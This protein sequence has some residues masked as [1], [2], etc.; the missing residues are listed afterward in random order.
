[1]AKPKVLV[2][3]VCDRF[4]IHQQTAGAR[5]T[6]DWYARFLRPFTARFG[7]LTVDD[8]TPSRV[9]QWITDTYGNLSASAQHAA[10]RAVV[11]AFNFAV[12]ER[13]IPTSPLIGFRKPA[14]SRRESTVTPVQY[15]ACLKAAV[16]S[17]RVDGIWEQVRL[18]IRDVIK[19]LWHTG[20]RPQELRIIEA[21]HVAGRKIVLPRELSKGK[22]R[23]RVIY[24]NDT[25]AAIVER[26][27]AEHPTGKLFRNSN[28][29]AWTK[30]ALAHAFRRLGRQA[31]IEG[32][33]CYS[34][35]HAWIT[36]QLE[37]G[38]DVAT[39]AALAGNSPRMVLDVYSHVAENEA[40]LL[41]VLG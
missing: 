39:V 41:T 38:T 30:T 40:R 6:Y 16:E 8:I 35:R 26:L 24:L 9:H 21:C 19:M 27:S 3:I 25:A 7:S 29:G 5:S 28:G 13:I 15:A 1:M 20:C 12:Q 2:T 22:R 34:F 31:G 18:P 23:Q 10:A 36:R 4:L 17:R 33:C 32:L 37:K 11:R 14:P